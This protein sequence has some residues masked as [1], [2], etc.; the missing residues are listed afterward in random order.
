MV[1]NDARSVAL[2]RDCLEKHAGEFDP[3]SNFHRK[4]RLGPRDERAYTTFNKLLNSGGLKAFIESHSDEFAW[5]PRDDRSNKGAVISWAHGARQPALGLV[6]L[7][8]VAVQSTAR[9][10]VPAPGRLQ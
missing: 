8:L 1:P 5:N 3:S 10:L 9:L 6:R 7:P 4:M 2:V